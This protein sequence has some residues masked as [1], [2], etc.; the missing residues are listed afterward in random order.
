LS[1]VLKRIFEGF[2]SLIGGS[3]GVLL[4]AWKK[5]LG[6]AP[7]VSFET[8]LDVYLRDP[9]AKA[10]VDFL[11]DQAVGMGFYTTVVEG[12][13]DA[14]EIID[15]FNESVNLD[16]LLQITA[17]E[18]VALGNSFWEKIEPDHLESLKLLPIISIDK[19]LRDRFGKV[20]GY[21]QTFA[22]GGTKIDPARVIHFCW[23][24]VAQEPFGTG[25]LH[26]LCTKLSLEGGETRPSYI[27]MKGAMEKGMTEIIRKYAGPTELW[28]FPGLRD[29]KANEYASKIKNM[30]R[31]GARFVVNTEAEVDVVTVDPR[32][33]FEAYVD[34]TWNQF[35]LGLQTP[36][37]KLFTTPGFTEASARAAIEVA[38]RKVMALQRF[39]KRIV[40]R[41]IFAPVLK[42]AGQN[43]VKAQVRLEWGL[44]E[45]PDVEALLP[46]LANIAK[47]RPDIISAKEFRKILVD[48]GLALEKT[49]EEQEPSE[50]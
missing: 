20:E 28:K 10:A 47:D 50:E 49:E 6:E 13:E 2:S 5:V 7:A 32:S 48:M 18:V 24:P 16:G 44:P 19:I 45:K 17:R 39:I 34:H 38:E 4:P 40:E 35:I 25:I 26:S 8:L 9:A 43:L 11:A 15:E 41:E 21:K 42:Q 27:V 29:D 33:R 31:E 14:K 46:M 36:L 3:R 30:P 37:P 23:N 1:K 22:Y 12:F